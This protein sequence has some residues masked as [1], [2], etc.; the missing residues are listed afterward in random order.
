MLL[1]HTALCARAGF[2]IDWRQSRK[3]SYLQ[4]LTAELQTPDKG[5][6]D[7]YFEPMVYRVVNEDNWLAQ[8]IALPGLDG[9]SQPDENVAY[10]DNDRA[11]LQRYSE[12]KRSREESL[13]RQT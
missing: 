11:A 9:S 6:L 3:N 13:T 8:I 12:A 1:V 7:R 2:S 5:I 4:S 10:Q